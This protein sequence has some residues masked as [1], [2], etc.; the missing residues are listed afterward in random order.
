MTK[1][2]DDDGVDAT[3]DLLKQDVTEATQFK[4]KIIGIF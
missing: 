3:D 2:V 4:E 1:E